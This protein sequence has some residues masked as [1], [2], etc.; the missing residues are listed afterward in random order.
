MNDCGRPRLVTVV[1]DVKKTIISLTKSLADTICDVGNLWKST[2]DLYWLPFIIL[3]SLKSLVKR[4]AMKIVKTVERWPT[5]Y[6]PQ[7]EHGTLPYG[8]LI[9]KHYKISTRTL[10]FLHRLWG[11]VPCS[12]SFQL[13]EQSIYLC[14]MNGFTTGM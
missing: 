7:D 11:S 8:E 14:L 1:A 4:E 13:E 10:Y 6:C 5:T 12:T 2:T 9:C 3:A